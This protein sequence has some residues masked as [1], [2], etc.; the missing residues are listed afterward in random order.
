MGYCNL[1]STRAGK[2]DKQQHLLAAAPWHASWRGPLINSACKRLHIPVLVIAN[3]TVM[4]FILAPG[5]W[6]VEP[7]MFQIDRPTCLNA[8]LFSGLTSCSLRSAF[9]V[10]R[11]HLDY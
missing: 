6:T 5:E 9:V 7:I 1:M 4:L 10:S 3:V 2:V 8:R 11:V